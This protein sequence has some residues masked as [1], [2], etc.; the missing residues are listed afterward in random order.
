MLRQRLSRPDPKP[1]FLSP[2]SSDN[3]QDMCVCSFFEC[4]A[5][6]SEILDGG[7]L[8]LLGK[9]VVVGSFWSPFSGEEVRELAF[10]FRRRRVED[11][12]GSR[13]A[14][15]VCDLVNPVL[16]F[17]NFRKSNLLYNILLKLFRD[18]SSFSQRN[19]RL[20]NTVSN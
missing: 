13:G 4:A 19:P 16:E 14:G 6:L 10:D 7:F 5:A 15:R 12:E 17:S 18:F 11:H 9:E 2:L 3:A 20:R 1:N 8:Q